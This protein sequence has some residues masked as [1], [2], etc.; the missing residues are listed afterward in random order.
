[1]SS[2]RTA[3]AILRTSAGSKARARCDAFLSGFVAQSASITFACIAD[4]RRCLV[5]V[6]RKTRNVVRAASIASHLTLG[7]SSA[8]EALRRDCVLSTIV[9]RD[10]IVLSVCI[11]SERERWRYMLSVG[12]DAKQTPNRL[13][14]HALDAA[15]TL[16]A[17][18]D[19]AA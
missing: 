17:I 6:P 2:A 10:G 8:R 9:T 3:G 13:L 5:A 1:M 7:K 11:P 18:L 4:S 19:S 15:E 12:A 14:H 16:A